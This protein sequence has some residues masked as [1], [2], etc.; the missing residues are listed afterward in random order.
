MPSSCRC[1][2]VLVSFCVLLL[3]VRCRIR[4]A[5]VSHAC[6]FLSPLAP[7][8]S[9][10]PTSPSSALSSPTLLLL[11]PTDL[12]QQPLHRLEAQTC[13]CPCSA[14]SCAGMFSDA[15][16]RAGLQRW[17]V[18]PAGP[19][20]RLVAQRLLVRYEKQG[21]ADDESKVCANGMT[22]TNVS[23]NSQTSHSPHKRVIHL[24]NH[25]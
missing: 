20:E 5:F 7:S 14:V 8:P 17:E 24:T 22:P 6:A 19:L 16:F 15:A 18:E 23:F 13:L 10:P 21:P 12:R 9:L 11:L 3:S 1:C 4:V 25:G 2:V